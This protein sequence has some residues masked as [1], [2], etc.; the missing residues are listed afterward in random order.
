MKIKITQATLCRFRD[1]PDA[2]CRKL[3]RCS[4]CARTLH[5]TERVVCASCKAL[6]DQRDRVRLRAAVTRKK[7]QDTYYADK[8]HLSK[9]DEIH[10]RLILLCM[11]MGEPI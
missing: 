5:P 6:A 7:S 2:A 8:I 3:S 1:R 10:E 11:K 4:S 9:I